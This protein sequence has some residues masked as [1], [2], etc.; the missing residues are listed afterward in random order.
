M[1]IED[2][3][4]DSEL[5][6]ST[7]VTTE[8]N[9]PEVEQG[10]QE[11]PQHEGGYNPVFEPIRQALG[12]QFETIKD[13]LLKI[14]NG[15]KDGI[16]KSNSK[17]APWKSFDEQGI[18]PEQVTSGFGLLQQINN[19]PEKI[20]TALHQFLKENGR[21][22]ETE[23]EVQQAVDDAGDDDLSDSD[24][25][26]AELQR[27]FEEQQQFLQAQQEQFQMAQLNAKAEEEVSREYTAFENAH[28]ELSEDDKREIYQRHYQYAASGPQNVR[29]LEDVAKEYLTLVDRIR[30]APRPND[31]APRLPGAG[32]GVP[33]GQRKSFAEL[34]REESQ[35]ALAELLEQNKQ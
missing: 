30:S 23:A 27:Q 14:E 35:S 12:V 22:P 31:T 32:G 34:S 4:Q 7:E 19:E 9:S 33:T 20:Y 16:T 5:D 2:Q 18:T 24:K 28:P 6:F 17:Y 1:D 8:E 21:L 15:F 3:G 25:K 29:P 13:D 10:S 11:Q 26:L